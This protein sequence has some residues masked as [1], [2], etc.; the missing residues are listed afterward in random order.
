MRTNLYFSPQWCAPAY[1]APR[2]YQWRP[3]EPAWSLKQRI[4]AGLVAFGFLAFMLL[5]VRVGMLVLLERYGTD[6]LH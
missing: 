3:L 6:F 5:L 2:W 1:A 4:V